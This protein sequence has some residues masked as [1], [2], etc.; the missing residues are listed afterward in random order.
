LW[1]A[2]TVSAFG[3]RITREGLPLAAVLAIGVG[4]AQLGL[5]AALTTGPGVIVGLFA[6]GLVDRSRRRSILIAAD[7]L[8]CLVLMIVPLAAWLNVL[9]IEQL[10]LAAAIVGSASIL[11]DIAD[12]AYLPSLIDRGQLIE[13]NAKL[14]IT[15]SVAEVGGPAIAGVLVQ[16]LTAPFAIAATAA[17]Y[18][19]SAAILS[20]IRKPEAMPV[21]PP[22]PK[23]WRQDVVTGF[24][25]TLRHPL[26]RPIFF[27]TV[28]ATF[29]GSFLAALYVFYAV[30][31]LGLTPTMLGMT[32]AA[33]GLG[34]LVGAALT[35]IVS[36]KIPL[37]PAI[38]ALSFAGGVMTLLIPFASGSPASRAGILMVVQFFGDGC[39]VMA[40]ISST[41]IRQTVLPLNVMGRVSAAFHVCIGALTAAGALSGGALANW[42]GIRETLVIAALGLMA[43]PLWGLI[44]PLRRL[45]EI[46]TPPDQA[47][48]PAVG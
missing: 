21:R 11:F 45:R 31:M 10:Y 29:F 13:G 17:S 2:Q 14:G 19:A 8:R 42:L 18:L 26:V 32:I 27:M 40:A 41:S 33:G 9:A 4:P 6:G 47:L 20:F 38:L 36:R 34:G 23:T 43:A 48:E 15:E 44:S 28:T 37:G 22:T 39:A 12:H 30:E 3:A 7:L 5:L 46:S 25:T 24:A 16:S 1:A 35:P